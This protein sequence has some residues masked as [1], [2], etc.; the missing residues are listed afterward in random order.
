[1]IPHYPLFINGE[2]KEIQNKQDIINPSSGKIIAK[3]SVAQKEE[4]EYAIKSA[5]DSFDNGPWKNLPFSERKK[6]V[7][8]IATGILEKAQELA[9]LESLNSGKPIKESTFMDIPSSAA[10]FDYFANNFEKFLNEETIKIESQIANAEAKLIREPWGVSVLIVP[11][12]Y[13]LLIASWKVAQA[14]CAGNTVILKPSSLTPLSALELAKIVKEAGLPAGAVNIIN[15]SGDAIG[16]VLC[17]DSRVD[18][19]SFTGSNAVG[20]KILEYT[21]K[22]VKKVTM[23]L[24]GKS[25]A[26]VLND[27][28]L[29]LAVNGLLCAI[30]LNQGQ[31]CTAMSRIFVQD[32]IY[33]NFINDFTQKAK[34][35]KIGSALNFETQ[36]G[37]LMS[38][39][40]RK[41]VLEYVK[42]GKKEGAQLLCGGDI[43]QQ[44]GLKNGF[45]FEPTVFGEVSSDMK[46][47]KEEIFGPVASV[48]K[49]SSIEEA[50][51]LANDCVFGL[52]ASVWTKDTSKA[53][54]LAKTINAGTVWVNTYGMFFNELPYGGFKQSGFGKELGKE[55]FLE[56][57]RIKN[58]V[59]D[60]TQDSKPLV[61]Y[62]Y[63][64]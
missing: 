24:G 47:F 59:I 61:N 49:F 35:I 52:A 4:I 62:W 46:I 53:Q 43:P 28:D 6:Y 19:I 48:A 34:R 54:S 30:F 2:F 31:M 42:Q 18:M 12:N 64:F 27:A 56:Y 13:P 29:E 11:W 1:M 14:L 38:E 15:G 60:K 57:T 33:D 39:S 7:L 37:P 36:I 17:S 20:K 63:G 8:K 16:E 55:G 26:I 44:E 21:A 10:T 5:R 25:A 58:V 40:Q 22:N 32:K 9:E 45:F 50:A 51:A 3:V 41:K 23:E